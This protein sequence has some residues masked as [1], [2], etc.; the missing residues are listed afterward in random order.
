M[1]ITTH[2]TVGA[3][4]GRA[5]R[6][7]VP[8]LA[9]GVVSHFVCDALPHWGNGPADTPSGLDDRTIRVAVADGL[10]GLALIAAVAKASPPASRV[11]VL[12]GITGACLPDMD[13]PGRLFFG[14]S[15]FPKAFD[16]LHV[17]VQREFP[18]LLTSDAAIAVAAGALLVRA[19]SRLPR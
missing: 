5:L 16:A 17:R 6:R 10:T 8:A 9:V 1:L 11:A 14:R 15:P 2:V 3:L 4:L 19:T 12:A 18:R 13:K 7:P